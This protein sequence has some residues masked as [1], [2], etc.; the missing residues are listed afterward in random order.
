MASVKR[1]AIA[2]LV[3]GWGVASVSGAETTRTAPLK[4]PT[5]AGHI[6]AEVTGGDAMDV[7]ELARPDSGTGDVTA[8][9]AEPGAAGTV[10]ELHG[11][12]KRVSKDWRFRGNLSQE[13]VVEGSPQWRVGATL[14]RQF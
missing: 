10:L 2:L 8:A 7:G 14:S 9:A 4:L 12:S 6:V 13:D 11:E 5:A 3:V 1:A